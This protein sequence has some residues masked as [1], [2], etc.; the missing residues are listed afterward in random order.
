MNKE[1]IETLT[2]VNEFIEANKN[3]NY[4]IRELER[5]VPNLGDLVKKINLEIKQ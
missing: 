5:E 1:I 3:V 2:K 4:K